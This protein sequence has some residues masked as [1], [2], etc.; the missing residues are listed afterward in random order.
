MATQFEVDV[1]ATPRLDLCGAAAKDLQ[2]RDAN[3]KYPMASRSQMAKEQEKL[4]KFLQYVNES[5]IIK[6]FS[7]ASVQE[8]SPVRGYTSGNSAPVLM[9]ST[10]YALCD[11]ELSHASGTQIQVMFSITGLAAAYDGGPAVA[12]IRI[13]EN[14]SAIAT[15]RQEVNGVVTVAAP[16]LLI[17]RKQGVTR[18]GVEASISSGEIAVEKYGAFASALVME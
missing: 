7:R 14:G 9:R 2:Y 8:R 1:V 5:F 3:G 13:L 16:F 6:G 18:L 11:F 17:N 15:F 12:Q 10:P 4:N